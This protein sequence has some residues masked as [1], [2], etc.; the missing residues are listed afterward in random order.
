MPLLERLTAV[1]RIVSVF[2]W[3]TIPANTTF[4]YTELTLADYNIQ[5]I[6]YCGAIVTSHRARKGF[7]YSVHASGLIN[8]KIRIFVHKYPTETVDDKV[9]V[10]VWILVGRPEFV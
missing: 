10:D 3:V 7:V 9:G 8:G 5:E 1:Y 6:E 2:V 4:G